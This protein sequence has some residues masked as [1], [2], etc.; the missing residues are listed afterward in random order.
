[1][2]QS[3]NDM[4]KNVIGTTDGPEG[5]SGIGVDSLLFMIIKESVDVI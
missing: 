2:N 4:L 3:Y 1:M 5:I